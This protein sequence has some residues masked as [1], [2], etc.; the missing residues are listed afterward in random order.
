MSFLR[1]NSFSFLFEIHSYGSPNKLHLFE[2]VRQFFL[3]DLNYTLMPDDIQ[4]F[5]FVHNIIRTT[6]IACTIE[7]NA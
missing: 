2:W 4:Q 3:L 1:N 7:I 6:N 5:F